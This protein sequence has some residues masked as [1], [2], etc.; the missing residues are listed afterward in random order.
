MYLRLF[1]HVQ[2]TLKTKKILVNLAQ[3]KQFLAQND[4]LWSLQ[5]TYFKI[6]KKPTST[7]HVTVPH[8]MGFRN[9]FG[10]FQE[11]TFPK[12]FTTLEVRKLWQAKLVQIAVFEHPTLVWRLFRK[13]SQRI[14]ACTIYCP[15]AKY[16]D[17]EV[18]YV[19]DW[20]V[21]VSAI[22]LHRPRSW[23]SRHAKFNLWLSG[24]ASLCN[25][26]NIEGKWSILAKCGICKEEKIQRKIK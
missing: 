26:R 5:V 22:C 2:L 24:I 23:A 12:L 3:T 21:A 1:W 13:L 10:I 16:M 9:P 20:S 8:L 25:E 18:Q 19:S 14:Y 17:M 7:T 11:C 6:N 4:T 15:K